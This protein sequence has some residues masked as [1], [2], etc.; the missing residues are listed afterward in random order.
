MALYSR[1]RGCV[2]LGVGL[3]SL[4]ASLGASLGDQLQLRPA[5]GRVAHAVHV[6]PA[7]AVQVPGAPA[8][9]AAAAAAPPAAE[10]RSQQLKQPQQP[11]QGPAAAA[12]AGAGC[13]HCGSPTPGPPGTRGYTWRRHPSTG[14]RLCGPC[15]QYA[16]SHGGALRPLAQGLKQQGQ[17]AQQAQQAQQQDVEEDEWEEEQDLE[18]EQEQEQEQ[19]EEEPSRQQHSSAAPARRQR[20]RGGAPTNWRG[21]EPVDVGRYLL[22][23]SPHVVERDHRACMPGKLHRWSQG[24]PRLARLH[25]AVV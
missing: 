11:R 2:L 4:L 8:A 6:K 21:L 24:V 14:S 16:G 19:E 3:G 22:V 5:G 23:L 20:R 9:A 1:R 12:L 10:R 7:S 25:V 17:Q 18:E 15:G 13:T